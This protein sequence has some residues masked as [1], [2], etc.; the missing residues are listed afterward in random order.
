M[1]FEIFFCLLWLASIIGLG[2]GALS[3]FLDDEWGFGCVLVV[4][5][6]AD[7]AGFIA[8]GQSV[9]SS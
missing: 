9:G 8:V 4:L 3:R 1:F 7:L 2:L 5:F 6:C